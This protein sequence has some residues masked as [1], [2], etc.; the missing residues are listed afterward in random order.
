[1]YIKLI[2][3]FLLF[4]FITNAQLFKTE[5]KKWNED[6]VSAR[7][8]DSTVYFLDT[9]QIKR[10]SLSFIEPDNIASI[11]AFFED[12]PDLPLIFKPYIKHGVIQLI[13]KNYAISVYRKE[14]SKIS[15]EYKELTKHHSNDWDSILYIIEGDTLTPNIEGKLVKMNFSQIKD[16]QVLSP[17]EAQKTYFDQGKYGVVFINSR[18]D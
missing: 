18:K 6:E 7:T 4:P 14:L 1:M 8:T 3:L 17:E 11:I 16:I 9:S 10:S 5:S 2:I 13:S 15:N 12:E